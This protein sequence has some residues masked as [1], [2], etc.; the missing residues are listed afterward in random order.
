MQAARR[1]AFCSSAAASMDRAPHASLRQSHDLTKTP[2]SFAL[3]VDASSHTVPVAFPADANPNPPKKV[4][5]AS[6]I[7]CSVAAEAVT[8]SNSLPFPQ[9]RRLLGRNLLLDSTDHNQ[10]A[11]GGPAVPKS[12]SASQQHPSQRLATIHTTFRSQPTI[13]HVDQKE[14]RDGHR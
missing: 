7:F 8:T 2:A 1:E 13:S 10:P 12:S 11:I 4:S 5:A 3:W 9:P 6:Q 14:S